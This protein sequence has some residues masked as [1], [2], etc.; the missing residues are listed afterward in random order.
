VRKN[1]TISPA[2]QREI[3]GSAVEGLLDPRPSR[4]AALRAFDGLEPVAATTLTGAW[5]GTEIPTSHRLNGLLP[6]MGWAGKTFLDDGRV[7]PLVFRDVGGGCFAVDPMPALAALLLRSPSLAVAALRRAAPL[8]RPALKGFRTKEPQARV[9]LRECRGRTGASIVYR[10]LPI[11][12]ALRRVDEHTL[13]GMMCSPS[14]DEPLFFV[15]RR[16]QPGAIGT[17]GRR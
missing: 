2:P 6:A 9:E 8:L 13:L 12:D 17:S 10:K 14:V 11:T 7:H 3:E 15:L 4:A 1:R 16:S 5:R